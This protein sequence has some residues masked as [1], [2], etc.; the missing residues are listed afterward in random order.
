M[1]QADRPR[2]STAQRARAIRTWFP[3]AIGAWKFL[4]ALDEG[5]VPQSD[6]AQLRQT[7]SSILEVALPRLLGSLDAMI[8]QKGGAVDRL[9]IQVD[10]R[11]FAL[12]SLSVSVDQD[13]I[14]LLWSDALR[15][16][17]ASMTAISAADRARVTRIAFIYYGHT[18]HLRETGNSR[19]PARKSFHPRDP[20]AVQ[21][22]RGITVAAVKFLISERVPTGQAHSRVTLALSS[23]F[24]GLKIVPGQRTIESWC[25]KLTKDKA[26][27][28][29]NGLR[30]YHS[31]GELVLE[32][33]ARVCICAYADFN[34]RFS[35]SKSTRGARHARFIRFIENDAVALIAMLHMQQ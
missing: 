27:A 9:A 13:A 12:E 10:N 25:A 15:Q 16:E 28:R 3:V 21:V 33:D 34:S 35:G 32:D 14:I 17:W 1:S 26:G 20:M 29:P 30:A 11:R 31:T 4:S 8:E 23:A 5:L 22:L 7:L 2:I 19:V 18:L 24:A 6:G